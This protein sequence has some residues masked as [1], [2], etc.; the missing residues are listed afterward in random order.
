LKNDLH[1]KIEYLEQFEQHR[2]ALDRDGL[3]PLVSRYR[4]LMR[5]KLQVGR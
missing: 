1:D 3:P 5:D 4:E 2:T